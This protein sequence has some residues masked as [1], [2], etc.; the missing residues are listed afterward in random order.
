MLANILQESNKQIFL[1][2][3]KGRE[4]NTILCSVNAG[5]EKNEINK[6]K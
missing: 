5:L 2:Y 6:K 4:K 3:P 1:I